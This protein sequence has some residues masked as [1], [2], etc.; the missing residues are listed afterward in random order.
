LQ[1]YYIYFESSTP[2]AEGHYAIFAT[3]WL[4]TSHEDICVSFWFNMEGD[5]GMG[6]F[7][8]LL[9]IPGEPE[10]RLLFQTDGP[11][12][13]EWLNFYQQ[14][15]IPVQHSFRLRFIATRG[16]SFQSD[17]AV[18]ECVNSIQSYNHLMGRLFYFFSRRIV[19][20][21]VKDQESCLPLARY[22]NTI[23]DTILFCDFD[24]EGR[25]PIHRKNVKTSYAWQA[26]VM[27]AYKF[28]TGP[29][30]GKSMK[31]YLPIYVNLS[32][33]KRQEQ[34]LT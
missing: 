19:V 10:S 11:H 9:D 7:D 21:E 24:T 26:T 31:L 17:I 14:I 25:C 32:I 2:A 5:V 12:G 29:D 6:M 1:G 22:P 34:Q 13:K 3:P 30:L 15:R 18:D 16:K 27:E 20:K 28:G 23:K 33:K 8:V 4:S